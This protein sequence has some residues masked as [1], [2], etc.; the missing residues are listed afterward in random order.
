MVGEVI[1]LM[2]FNMLWEPFDRAVAQCFMG[3][4]HEVEAAVGWIRDK[5]WAEDS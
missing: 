5:T 1:V 3:G 2:S 4:I